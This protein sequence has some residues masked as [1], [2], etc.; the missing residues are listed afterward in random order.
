V[1]YCEVRAPISGRVSRTQLDQGNLVRADETVLA[2]IVAMDPMFGYFELDERTLLKLRRSAEE[3]GAINTRSEHSVPVKMALADEQGY[4]HDG[5]VDYF[6]NQLDPSTGTM[7]ARGVFKNADRMLA[8]GMFVR[9]RLPIGQPYRALLLSEQALGTD[10]GQKFVYVVDEQSKVQYRRVDVG[11]LQQGKRVVL[12][13]IAE[14][15][16]VVVSGLQRVRP[17]AEVNARPAGEVPASGPASEMAGAQTPGPP[18][19]H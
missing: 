9:V 15:D 19:S 17:G 2:T 6:D 4:P 18:K 7:Q 11:K 10:Q 16:R 3:Q 14:G 13:G 8:P 1:A 5:V 12:D